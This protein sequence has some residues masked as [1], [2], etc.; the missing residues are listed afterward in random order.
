MG[1]GSDTR[2]NCDFNELEE[3]DL[4]WFLGLYSNGDCS[5]NVDRKE[6]KEEKQNNKKSENNVGSE[7]N[8]TLEE[9]DDHTGSSLSNS[10]I[11]KKAY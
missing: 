1:D 9:R 7:Q 11:Y 4:D 2:I 8:C 3:L 6:I 5:K 10:D